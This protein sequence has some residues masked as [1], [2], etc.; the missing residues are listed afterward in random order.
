VTAI[1]KPGAR[2]RI[3]RFAVNLNATTQFR[4]GDAQDIGVGTLIQVKGRVNDADEIDASRVTFKRSGS[5]I[6]APAES[7]AD[8][9]KAELNLLGVIVKVTDA[10]EVRDERDGQS[11]FGLGDIRPGDYLEVSGFPCEEN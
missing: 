10:T 2:F 8:L 4:F 3:S 1:D 11:G 6:A 5:R 9:D 7:A